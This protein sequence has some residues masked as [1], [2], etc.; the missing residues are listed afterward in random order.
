MTAYDHYD[1]RRQM[2]NLDAQRREEA[3]QRRSEMH[4]KMPEP[5]AGRPDAPW[6][7]GF[8]LRFTLQLVF[9]TWLVWWMLGSPPIPIKWLQ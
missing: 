9:W 4:R 8:L 1:F 5:E 3:A 7:L 2:E 6:Q